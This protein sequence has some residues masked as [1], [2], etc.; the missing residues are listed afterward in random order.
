MEKRCTLQNQVDNTTMTPACVQD[1]GALLE[2]LLGLNSIST[3]FG[4]WMSF[5]SLTIRICSWG[6]RI[7]LTRFSRKSK[8]SY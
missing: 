6:S 5:V 1:E 8:A 3:D 4:V 2:L 7:G